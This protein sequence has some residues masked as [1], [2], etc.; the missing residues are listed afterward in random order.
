VHAAAVMCRSAG[1]SQN[2]HRRG[3]VQLMLLPRCD[4]GSPRARSPRRA[5]GC[6]GGH[7]ELA[8]PAIIAT[9]ATGRT[10]G[11]HSSGAR[12]MAMGCCLSGAAGRGGAR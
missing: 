12:D 11:R 4:E 3:A 10:A 8:N 5:G 9:I 7:H 2:A 1:G 6:A